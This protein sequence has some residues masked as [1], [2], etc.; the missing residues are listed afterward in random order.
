MNY[1][2][3]DDYDICFITNKLKIISERH[4]SSYFSDLNHH[5]DDDDSGYCA[6]MH[7]HGDVSH[8]DIVYQKEQ[9][10]KKNHR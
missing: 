3:D 6:Y 1:H 4:F 2:G 10:T 7:R 8:H 9:T 5:D